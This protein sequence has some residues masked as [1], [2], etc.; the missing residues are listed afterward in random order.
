MAEAVRVEGTGPVVEWAVKMHRLPAEA[1]LASSGRSRRLEPGGSSSRWPAGSRIFIA[2]PSA[3][4]SIARFGRFDVVARNVRDNFDQSTSQVGT[5]VSRAVFDRLR[6][7]DRGS[8]WARHRA[9]IE[10]R[11]ARGIPCDT[12][13]DIRMDHV[14][15]FPDNPPP[16]DMAIVDCLEFNLRFRAADPVADMAFLVMDL[17]RH[18]HRELARWFRDAYFAYGRR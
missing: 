3:T 14:Y 8:A 13:G 15:L 5:T 7:A 12:H 17:I 1:S 4:Q 2:M 6:G 10:D 18:G 11:A 9:L 16:D